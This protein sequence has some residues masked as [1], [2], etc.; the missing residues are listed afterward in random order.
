[1]KHSSLVRYEADGSNPRV[2][3]EPENLANI[4]A[5]AAAIRLAE[6]TVGKKRGW[7]KGR[8]RPIRRTKLAV[9]GIPSGVLDRGNPSYARCLRLASAYRKVRVRELTISHGFVSSGAS[10]LLASGAHALAASRYLYE[11]A[12]EA[13]GPEMLE[14]LRLAAK[15]A[16]S[17]RANELAAWEL[18]S[19]EGVARKRSAALSGGMPWIV[20]NEEKRGRGRPPKDR[21][22]G[23][24][25]PE[26][27]SDLTGWVSQ[28]KVEDSEVVDGSRG[29]ETSEGGNG[30][31]QAGD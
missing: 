14:L 25:L 24:F 29:G 4:D 5:D 13:D 3:V 19:R 8:K 16:D 10:A 1:M 18:C 30:S 22:A 17:T 21:D 12:A 28:A 15:L 20:P 6:G 31:G 23:L 26:P 7:P 2:R 11:K 9:L 27:G